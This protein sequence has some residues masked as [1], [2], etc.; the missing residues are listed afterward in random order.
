MNRLKKI[1]V[2]TILAII[3]VATNTTVFAGTKDILKTLGEVEYS[4]D[5]VEWLELSEEERLKIREP[6][7]YDILDTTYES[8]NPIDVVQAVGTTMESRFTL[9]DYIPE[10]MIVRNQMQTGSCWAFASLGALESNLA[11]TNYYNNKEAKVYDLSE[12]HMEYSATRDFKSGGV[13]KFGLNRK[14]GTGGNYLVSTSYL[15][16]GLGAVKEEDMPFKNELEQVAISE[17]QGKEVVTQLYDTIIFPKYTINDD[18]DPIKLK[19]KE[20]IKKYGAIEAGIHGAQ[21]LSD[22][23]NNDT[24]AS[25]SDNEA[26]CPPNHD[27]IIVGWDDNYPVENFNELHRPKNKG[28]WIARN[29]WGTK[30]TY[31]MEEMQ[32]AIFEALK[33]KCIEN[34]WTKPNMIPTSVAKNVFKELGYEIDGDSA[35]LIVGDNGFIYISYEDV[36]VYKTLAGILKADDKVSYDYLYQY[37]ELGMTIGI[38]LNVDTAYLGSV[39]DKQSDGKEY[40]TGI[41]L[42]TPETYTVTVFAN[43][44]DGS[45]NRSKMAQVALKEGKS[46]TFAAGYHTIEFAEPLEITG[47]QFAVT[48]KAKSSKPEGITFA[49]EA[50]IPNSK[51]DKIELT[52]DRTFWTVDGSYEIDEWIDLS[53][54]KQASGGKIPSGDFVMKAFTI[55]EAEVDVLES[56]T[57]TTPPE[58]IEY[59]EGH[60]FDKTGMIVKASYSNGSKK[61]ITDY[62]IV[63]G[64]DLKVDQTEVTIKYL[65]KEAKQ[66]IKVTAKVTEKPDDGENPTDKP[67]DEPKEEKPVNSDFENAKTTVNSAKAYSFTDKTKKE[68]IV[69]DLTIKSIKRELE[70]NDKFEYYYYLSDSAAEKN[71]VDWVKISE[72][73]LEKDRLDFKVNTQD[74]KNYAEIS[75]ASKLYI[76]IKEVAKRDDTQKEFVTKAITVGTTSNIEIYKDGVKQTEENKNNNNNNNQNNNN[77]NNNNNNNNN[78]NQ[79]NNNNNQNNNNQNNNNQD[80][81]VSKDVLP[82]AGTVSIVLIVI[83]IAIGGIVALKKYKEMNF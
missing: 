75:K 28:A 6:L 54:L 69:I 52:K 66:K 63:D 31:S 40:L 16:N 48:I 30:L 4:A 62:E 43:T 79:N 19:M 44:K 59:V 47:D 29:S 45:I 12:R 73:Q 38:P 82:A 24:G 83:I 25:Y 34:G 15:T 57:I 33:E 68:Y 2:I 77:Q 56:I 14:L 3:A 78:S 10:N 26:N 65:D 70:K 8:N 20:H 50:P 81:T 72:L 71:I 23:Y 35:Y 11:L 49:L 27:V 7:P 76:Y 37:D 36:N 21:I 32:K 22:Y 1:L 18:L 13:N 17:I 55:K 5:F 61:Q 58:K 80:N 67:V 53:E 9:Q 74:V 42:Y 60:D 46:E 41:S 64:E 51:Y 39:F